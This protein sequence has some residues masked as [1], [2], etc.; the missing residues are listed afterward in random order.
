MTKTKTSIS[1]QAQFNR[2]Y[3][4]WTTMTNE[5]MEQQFGRVSLVLQNQKFYNAKNELL[6]LY[7]DIHMM[8]SSVSKRKPKPPFF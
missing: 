4:N 3:P 1:A 2:M 5:Q 8:R 7:I 6:Q